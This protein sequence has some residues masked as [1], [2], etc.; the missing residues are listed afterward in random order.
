MSTDKSDDQM[1]VVGGLIVH[2][3]RCGI[4]IT[5]PV[6][7]GVVTRDEEPGKLF[8]RTDADVADY[9]SHAFTHLTPK[10]DDG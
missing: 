9:W 10:E 1:L 8:I 5:V 3:P 7:A 6:S 4:E 2:C